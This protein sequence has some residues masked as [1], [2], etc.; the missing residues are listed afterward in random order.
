[1]FLL[2]KFII[3][4]LSKNYLY[5]DGKILQT[6]QSKTLKNKSAVILDNF[7]FYFIKTKSFLLEDSKV[8]L[9]KLGKKDDTLINKRKKPLKNNANGF[10]TEN[11]IETNSVKNSG[12]LKTYPSSMNNICDIKDNIF[13]E[14]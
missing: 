14:L 3:T 4:N 10:S 2:R 8:I 1:L 5:V 9:E 7:L 12:E 11:N 13:D 6:N